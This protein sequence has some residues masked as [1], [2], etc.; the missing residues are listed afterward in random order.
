MNCGAHNTVGPTTQTLIQSFAFPA[1][2]AS[3]HSHGPCLA[4]VLRPVPVFASLLLEELIELQH[5]VSCGHEGLQ[6]GQHLTEE[7]QVV[8][9]L[10]LAVPPHV[11]AGA[12]EDEHGALAHIEQVMAVAQDPL[13][14]GMCDDPQA[15]AVS[16]VR[17]VA[18]RGGVIHA[19]HTLCL[20]DLGALLTTQQMPRAS[21]QGAILAM[22]FQGLQDRGGG[23]R[24]CQAE[25][26]P[27]SA[28][29]G[30]IPVVRHSV[31]SLL[32]STPHHCLCLKAD[33]IW[34]IAAA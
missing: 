9:Y 7:L 8:V 27:A 11:A 10:A 2:V 13:D 28:P 26:S 5:L 19:D 30:Y 14:A 21:H 29:P 23:E 22:H 4:P 24:W 6:P 17:P 3:T 1:S 12:P 18:S 20:I 33:C 34:S 32:L 31:S 25:E 16:H 15:R